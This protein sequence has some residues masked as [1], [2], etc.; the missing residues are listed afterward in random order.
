MI[1]DSQNNRFGGYISSQ[2]TGP[3]TYITD[4][5]AF[6]YSLNSN[7][8]LSGPTQFKL[9]YPNSAFISI[10]THDRYIFAFGGGFDLKMDKKS[11]S[12][13]AN[14]NPSSYTFN[15]NENALYGK[16]Y[17]DRFTPKRWVVYQMEKLNY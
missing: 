13:M 17:P 16:T 10:T 9:K 11:T 4:P 2:I 14:S 1:T 3:D 6:L 15:E 12:Y 8:R 5:N 7:G